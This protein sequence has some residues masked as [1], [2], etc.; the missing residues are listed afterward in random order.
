MCAPSAA[1][2]TRHAQFPC[3]S[4]E[5]VWDRVLAGHVVAKVNT[6]HAQVCRI[7]KDSADVWWCMLSSLFEPHMLEDKSG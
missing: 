1:H 7:V 3:D 4:L 2:R 6:H 5:G